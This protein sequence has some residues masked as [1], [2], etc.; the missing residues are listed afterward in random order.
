MSIKTKNL[1]IR[2]NLQIDNP[3]LEMSKILREKHHINLS[4]LCR[5]AIVNAYKKIEN[6]K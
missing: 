1:K 5:E 3:T 2:L 6:R 4:S